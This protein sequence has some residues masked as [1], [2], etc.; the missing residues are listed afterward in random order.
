MME[1]WSRAVTVA[2]ALLSAAFVA[3]CGGMSASEVKREYAAVVERSN[4]CTETPDCVVVSGECP[5]PCYA[6]VN[7]AAAADVRL[8]G[9]ELIDEYESGGQS[10]DY[11]CVQPPLVECVSSRCELVHAAAPP[12]DGGAG[13]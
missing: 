5:L 6:A 9:R 10:C 11:E 12:A 1:S 8:R 3:G 7:R 4:Q 2:A 13:G